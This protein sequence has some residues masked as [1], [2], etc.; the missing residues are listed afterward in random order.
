MVR[1]MFWLFPEAKAQS[2]RFDSANADT[3]IQ[4]ISANDEE[5]VQLL[6]SFYTFLEEVHKFGIIIVIISLDHRS[7]ILIR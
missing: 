4:A 1:G 6:S 7:N 3:G 5:C 2:P